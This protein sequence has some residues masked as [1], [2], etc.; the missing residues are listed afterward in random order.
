M[1]AR[2]NKLKTADAPT[3]EKKPDLVVSLLDSLPAPPIGPDDEEVE[4]RASE[5]ESG[6][7]SPLTHEQFLAETGHR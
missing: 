3:R 5:M 7:V 2:S 4:K 1:T 6:E